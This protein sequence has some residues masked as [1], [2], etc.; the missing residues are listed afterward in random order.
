MFLGRGSEE[1]GMLG[2]G[3]GRDDNYLDGTEGMLEAN[4]RML[5]VFSKERRAEGRREEENITPV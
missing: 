5:T 2:K 3:D 4:I 1:S